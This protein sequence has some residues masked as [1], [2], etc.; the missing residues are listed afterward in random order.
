MIFVSYVSG[1]RFCKSFVN[2]QTRIVLR[3]VLVIGAVVGNALDDDLGIVTAGEGA[4]RVCP[5]AFRLAFVVTGY[6]PSSL[7]RVREMAW[8][9]G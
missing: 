9:F 2:R 3:I 7:S 5:I 8:R 4:L 1:I 6:R